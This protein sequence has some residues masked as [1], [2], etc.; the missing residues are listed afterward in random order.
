MCLLIW[1]IKVRQKSKTRSKYFFT[2]LYLQQVCNFIHS[3]NMKGL[4]K[5][6]RQRRRHYQSIT[7]LMQSISSQFSISCA[8]I[9]RTGAKYW[10]VASVKMT[11][12]FVYFCQ[13]SLIKP[14]F[15]HKRTEV[16]ALGVNANVSP[17]RALLVSPRPV[18]VRACLIKAFK[19]KW[20]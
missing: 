13:N 5:E 14:F 15:S 3:V 18:N 7:S 19:A 4:C 20:T 6:Q 11:H 1:K 12:R 10:S 9:D 8:I 16:R 17:R 2:A